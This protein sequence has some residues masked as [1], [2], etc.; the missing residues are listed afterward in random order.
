M[1]A[2]KKT[3]QELVTERLRQANQE[4]TPIVVIA[5]NIRSLDNVG[6]LFRSCELARVKKLYLTGYTGYPRQDKDAR[7]KDVADRHQRRIE[8]TA[9]YALAHQPWEYVADAAALVKQLKDDEH[10]IV[11][12]EQTDASVPY[13]EATYTSPTAIIVGHEREGVSQELI[14]LADTVVEIPVLGMGNSHNAAIATSIVLYKVLEQT[15]Q[16]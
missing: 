3:T 13:H 4:R 14:D 5:D 2:K 1:T 16:V 12:L 6:L 9:V 7:P 8:K 11:A 15:N 10:Q